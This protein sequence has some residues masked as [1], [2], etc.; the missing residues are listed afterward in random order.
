MAPGQPVVTRRNV[1]CF[2]AAMALLWT[3]SD[4]PLHDIGERYLYSGHMLQHMMLSYFL[5]PLAL[6]AT[7]EWLLRVLVGDGRAYRVL[8]WLCKPIVAGLA[9]NLAV[10]VSHIPGVVNTSVDLV[11]PDAALRRPRHGRRHGPADVDAG[12]R[13]VPRVAHGHAG[14]DDLP[15]PAVGGADDPGR[16]V[17]LRRGQRVPGLRPTGAGLGHVR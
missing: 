12:V 3:A 14:Q 15:V 13:A 5:P 1:W 7:P 16:L 8:A 10:I 17:G 4:W 9:F 11:E 6:L 2:V